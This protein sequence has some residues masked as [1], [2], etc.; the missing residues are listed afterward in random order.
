MLIRICHTTS[1]TC[2]ST[3]IQGRQIVKMIAKSY[4]TKRVNLLNVILFQHVSGPA[5]VLT[6]PLTCSSAT[7]QG[8]ERTSRLRE[9]EIW[10]F[11]NRICTSNACLF[12]S[13]VVILLLITFLPNINIVL[14]DYRVSEDKGPSIMWD[15]CT[16]HC[17]D[18]CPNG[19]KCVEQCFTLPDRKE[20]CLCNVCQSGAKLET[21]R[22]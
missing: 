16:E 4:V 21:R 20:R 17:S 2:S 7:T 3:I 19:K 8:I 9:G 18:M 1:T 22:G 15:N 12:K 6:M 14:L 13:Y 10:N 11:R 5:T